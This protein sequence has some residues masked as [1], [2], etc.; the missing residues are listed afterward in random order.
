VFGVRGRIL[1]A[2]DDP[3]RT[4]VLTAAEGWMSFQY[5][6]VAHGHRTPISDV[7]FSGAATAKPADGVVAAITEAD[8]VVV[9]PSNPPLSIWPI[10]AVP[11][12]GEAMERAKRVVAVSPLIGGRP[13]KGPADRVMRDLGL[14][15]GTAGVLAAYPG[16]LDV[17][18]VD[19]DDEADT[20]LSDGR[21]R[22]LAAPTRIV[23]PAA[24]AALAR[25]LV[26]A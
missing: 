15:E 6:F 12:I 16:L 14:P 18:V 10:L 1:P 3:V 11:E 24:A 25:F 19:T 8:L 5:Y 26:T 23:D 9:G 20:G 13:L 7:R 21:T 4:Q 2:S 22:V 17:L